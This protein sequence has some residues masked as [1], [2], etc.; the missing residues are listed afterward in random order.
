MTLPKS[1]QGHHQATSQIANFCDA[2]VPYARLRLLAPDKLPIASAT[3]WP[4]SYSWD[5]PSFVLSVASAVHAC[6]K[7]L[8][9]RQRT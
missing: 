3:L 5:P 1:T 7:V 8:E 2:A 6:L 4:V 9:K